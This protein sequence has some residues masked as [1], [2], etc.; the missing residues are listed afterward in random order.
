M[1]YIIINKNMKTK[2]IFSLITIVLL[3]SACGK[4][5]IQPEIPASTI[6]PVLEEVPQE[7]DDMYYEP[8]I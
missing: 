2:Y 4:K 8:E 1:L 5:E 6:T 3:L 7:V